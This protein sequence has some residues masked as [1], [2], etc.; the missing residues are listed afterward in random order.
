[1]MERHFRGCLNLKED[2]LR[3]GIE[4]DWLTGYNESIVQR[5]RNEL[6][7]TFL[8]TKHTHLF[9]LD[10]D[11]EFTTEDVSK[12]WNMR[13]DIGVGCYLMKK[14]GL[15]HFTAWKD[16]KMVNVD[17]YKEPISV[18]YA[19]T[20]FMCIKREVIEAI[21]QDHYDFEKRAEKLIRRLKP[22]EDVS[23][24]EE[25]ILDRLLE[26]A[27]VDYYSP[28]SPGSEELRIAQDIYRTRIWEG[29]YESED[30]HI[31]R[32]A[33]ELGFRIM[34]EPTVKL[35]H[36]GLFPYGADVA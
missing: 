13:A 31:C 26:S 18:D 22:L 34:M 9:W 20:G 17:D 6:T 33:R 29:T 19:G 23:L 7:R 12:V 36:W 24:D 25:V 28:K 11:I 35:T 3:A 10:A 5:A 30:Y 16:G 4:H 15:P 1:M 14:P 2:L 8:G 27:A 32:K 21:I